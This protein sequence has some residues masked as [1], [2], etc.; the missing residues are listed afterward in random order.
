MAA[1]EHLNAYLQTYNVYGPAAAEVR[2]AAGQ[3]QAQD[4]NA[5]SAR[6]GVVPFADRNNPSMPF[7]PRLRFDADPPSSVPEPA[8][9]GLFLC[10]GLGGLFAFRRKTSSNLG[11]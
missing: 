4:T 2:P 10:A 7:D 3:L 6:T 5:L 8:S 11:A 9:L 1:N